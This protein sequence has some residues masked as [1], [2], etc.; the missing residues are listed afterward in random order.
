MKLE[1]SKGRLSF[2]AVKNNYFG[3]VFAIPTIILMYIFTWRPI[4]IGIAYSFFE[5]EGFTP[6][7]F[8]GF[9]NYRQILSDTN[10]IQVLLNTVKYC[11][12]SLAFSYFTPLIIAVMVNEMIRSKGYFKFT[13]YL[14]TVIPMVA[15]CM[16]FKMI[17]Y[18]DNSGLMNMLLGKFGVGPM[19]FLS[20]KNLVIPL[21]AIMT[22]WKGMGSGMIMY[23]ASLQGVDQ[24]QYEAARIDGAG[25]F[26]RIRYVLWPHMRGIMLLLLVTHIIGTF[27]ICEEPMILTGG[28]P[29]G[30]STTL[31][32]MSYMYAFQ[33]GQNEKSIALGMVKFLILMV[34]TVIYFGLDKKINE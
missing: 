27:N 16:L 21:I 19:K 28:G 29:N 14:P 11:F 8:I 17:Y 15:C 22:T 3:W 1:E 20:N 2:A 25:V 10:F 32:Y 34:L 24:S 6:V 5:L 7:K 9:E 26:Q 31:G 12:W 13:L 4:G 30:A 18:D 23:L 33:F